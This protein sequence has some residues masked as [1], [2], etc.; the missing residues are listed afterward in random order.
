MFRLI[1]NLI[2]RGDVNVNHW[3]FHST[4]SQVELGQMCETLG[5]FTVFKCLFYVV[6]REACIRSSSEM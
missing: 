3:N 6:F 1:N 4:S 2:G 5:G